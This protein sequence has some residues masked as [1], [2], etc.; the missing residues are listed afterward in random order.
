MERN[1]VRVVRSLSMSPDTRRFLRIYVGLPAPN[2]LFHLPN[3]NNIG[4]RAGFRS[5]KR[6][7]QKC[8][9]PNHQYKQFRVQLQK[10]TAN[11]Q[12]QL[13]FAKRYFRLY[14]EYRQN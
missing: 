4:F 3:S 8:P 9:P 7:H 1:P 14:S 10:S 11:Q 5:L 6:R 13:R 2:V 12:F